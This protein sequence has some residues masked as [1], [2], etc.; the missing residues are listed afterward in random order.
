MSRSTSSRF[1]PSSARPSTRAAN[2]SFDGPAHAAVQDHKSGYVTPDNPVNRATAPLGNSS[3]SLNESVKDAATTIAQA[4][5]EQAA[6]VA[7]EV[8]HELGQT[9]DEQISRGADAIRGFARAV[10]A[11]TG[12][13]RWTF[14]SPPETSLHAAL[15]SGRSPGWRKRRS[16]A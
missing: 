8:G 3:A 11:A 16:T 14:T 1:E 13:T 7:S 5:K 2:G 9:A 15:R 12:R 6:S 4:V 10:D